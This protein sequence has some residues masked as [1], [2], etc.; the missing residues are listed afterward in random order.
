MDE[1]SK[2]RSKKQVRAQE[3]AAALAALPLPIEELEA[4]FEMLDLELE[5]Q[6]CDH[7]RR[8]T[9]AWLVTRGHD[10]TAVFPWLDEH[11][12]YCDCEV[13]ANVPDEVEEAKKATE[14]PAD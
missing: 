14:S 5:T 4:M 1:A 8:I 7:S 13:L 2:R 10:P 6:S 11:G 12:G 9:Q 3:R